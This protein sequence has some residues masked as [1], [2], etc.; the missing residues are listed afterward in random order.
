MPKKKKTQAV[1]LKIVPQKHRS[2]FGGKPELPE[3]VVWPVSPEGYELDFLAQIHFPEISG[4]TD[5]P[6]EG[7]LFVFYD[8]SKMPAYGRK[9]DQGYWQVI[10]T[11]DALPEHPREPAGEKSGELCIYRECFLGFRSLRS[12]GLESEGGHR[13]LGKPYELQHSNMAPGYLLLLQI[14]SDFH[15]N[16]PGWTWCDCGV[17]YFFIKP[18]DLAA[19]RFDRVRTEWTCC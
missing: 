17:L 12:D 11:C 8:R 10:Y 15:P 2:K 18:E 13:M 9:E 6:E 14:D 19:R 7:T 5:L 16:G 4:G 1:G 3:S